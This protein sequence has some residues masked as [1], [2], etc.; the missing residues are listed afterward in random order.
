MIIIY[1]Y[2]WCDFDRYFDYVCFFFRTTNENYIVQ[3]HRIRCI[4]KECCDF[5]YI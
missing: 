3:T 1:I 4:H 2:I 5:D